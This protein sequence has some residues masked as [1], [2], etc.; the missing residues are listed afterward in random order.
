MCSR[1]IMWLLAKKRRNLGIQTLSKVIDGILEGSEVQKILDWLKEA[2]VDYE[3][4]IKRI[5]I[6]VG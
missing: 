6:L 4:N 3:E 2:E 5:Q 1:E